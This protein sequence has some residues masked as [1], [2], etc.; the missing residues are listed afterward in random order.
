MTRECDR[1]QTVRLRKKDSPFCNKIHAGCWNCSAVVRAQIIRAECI[2]SNQQE[3]ITSVRV[4]E[5][6]GCGRRHK[7]RK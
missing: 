4:Q 2:D 7:D 1:N 3:I 5:M 6:R